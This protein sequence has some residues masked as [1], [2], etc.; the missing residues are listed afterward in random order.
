M[1]EQGFFTATSGFGWYRAADLKDE[2]RAFAK[3]TEKFGK[4]LETILQL[5]EKSR[6]STQI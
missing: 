4:I 1:L 3:A 2:A 5:Q 6:E